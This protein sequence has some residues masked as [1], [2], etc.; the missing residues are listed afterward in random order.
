MTTTTGH[1]RSKRDPR[2]PT[3]ERDVAERLAA[4][5][6]DRVADTLDQLTPEQWRAQTDCTEWDVRAMAGHMLG[7]V[8]MIASW[9]EMMRQQVVSARRAK[10]DGL[11]AIDALTAMQVEENAQLSTSDLIGQIR[12]LAPK[13]VKNRRRA[14]GVVRKQVMEEGDEWWSMGYLF[15]VILTR[16]PFLHRVDIAHATGLPMTATADHEGVLIDDV[17]AEWAGRHGSDY[18]LELTGPAGGRWQRGD[19][20]GEHLVMDAFE[21]CRALSGRA[22]ADGLLR[23]QVPF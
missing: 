7:M 17:V 3:L 20:T 18:D 16:D 23:T 1:H 6:Y 22:P 9:P 13:A 19:G 2:L 5:E 8:Q 12:R 4:T 21:F 15:D 11:V 14:P 10:R